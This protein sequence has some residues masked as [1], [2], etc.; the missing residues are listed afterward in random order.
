M[1]QALQRRFQVLNDILKIHYSRLNGKLFLDKLKYKLL[2]IQYQIFNRSFKLDFL[3]S[4][5][6]NMKFTLTPFFGGY[7]NDRIHNG[8][9]DYL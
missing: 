8:T 4:F 2:G 7:S 5:K 9:P 1:R 3:N 6:A